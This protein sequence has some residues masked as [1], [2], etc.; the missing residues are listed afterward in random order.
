MPNR[1]PNQTMEKPTVKNVQSQVRFLRL[2]LIA[3]VGFP[4]LFV[5]NA[6]AQLAAPAAPAAAEATAERVIVTGSNIPTAEETGP[7][8]VD[9]YR[10][11]DIEKLGIRNAQDLQT[12][13]PQE[14]GGTVNTNISNGGDGTVQ[15]NLRGILAKETLVLIDG[16]RVALPS[17]GGAGSFAG[18]DINLIPFVMVDHIDILKDG[19]SAVYGADAVAGVVNFFLVHK[20]RGLEIG[21]TYGNTNLGASN[22]MG[23]WEAW[24]KAGTGDEKTD[25]VVIADF[26]ERTGGIFSADRKLSANAFFIPYGG[27]DARSINFPGAVRDERLLPRMFFGPG[28]NPVPGVNTPLPHS[29]PNLATSPFYADPF[30]VN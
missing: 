4:L 16:K 17:L 18:V 11:Q 10:P 26:W 22:E 5:G 21:G 29:A 6:F 2:A 24:L 23:E 13:I 28:G 30:V 9:T 25:I 19:A 14:A 27:F 8:P 1:K 20:F 3:S 15:F 12:F 7:N